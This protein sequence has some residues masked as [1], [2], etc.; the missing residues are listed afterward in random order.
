MMMQI[1]RRLLAPLCAGCWLMAVSA[2][3]EA[4]TA[5]DRDKSLCPCKTASYCD[6]PR[7]GRYC[8]TKKGKRQYYAPDKSRKKR[9]SKP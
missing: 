1:L 4:A 8:I 5:N 3:S 2:S 7:G 9:S 6:G